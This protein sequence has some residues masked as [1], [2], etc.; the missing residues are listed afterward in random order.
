M[1]GIDLTG[2]NISGI[3]DSE[4]NRAPLM[5][6]AHSYHPLV[7]RVE[8]SDTTWLQALDQFGFR[9]RDVF[10]ASQVL[11]VHRSD[12][13]F[14]GDIRRR[15]FAEPLDLVRGRRHSHLEYCYLKLLWRSALAHEAQDRQ[16]QTKAV[17]VVALTLQHAPTIRA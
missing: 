13:Q 10:Y 1:A 2:R 5:L 16:R 7:I 6:L 11:Q 3:I 9:R 8:N 12:H 14:H 17:V 15:D 4:G